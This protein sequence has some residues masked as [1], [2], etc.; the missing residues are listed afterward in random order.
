MLFFVALFS[1]LIVAL[2]LGAETFWGGQGGTVEFTPTGGS[3][4]TVANK[5]WKLKKA[6]RVNEV[7][8]AGSLNQEQWI[9]GVNQQEGS[10]EVFYDSSLPPD[11]NG[12]YEGNT[13]TLVSN[14]GDSTHY[15]SQKV[16]IVSVEPALDAQQGAIMYTVSYKGIGA[17]TYT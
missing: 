14:L 6:N 3:L 2:L 8:N 12:L 16:I 13:G 5:S 7:T 9:S 15:Y 17:I 4:M 10:F 1:L 11:S